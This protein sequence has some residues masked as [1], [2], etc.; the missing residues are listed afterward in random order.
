MTD[1]V[2]QL[3]FQSLVEEIKRER[4]H[5]ETECVKS[6]HNY[7]TSGEKQ[8]LHLGIANASSAVAYKRLLSF[9]DG[10]ACGLGIPGSEQI[11]TKPAT[12]ASA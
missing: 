3:A 2:Y 10:C 11:T 4:R 12:K 6:I 8:Q 5:S 9:I 1:G 7:I